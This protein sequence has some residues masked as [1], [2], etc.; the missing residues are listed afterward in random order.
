MMTVYRQQGIA[1]IQVL[2]IAA[3][4]SIFSI[5]IN[6]AAKQQVG[7]AKDYVEKADALLKL[8]T[9]RAQLFNALLTQ[10]KVQNQLSDNPISAVWNFYNKPFEMENGVTVQMQDMAGLLPINQLLRKD[11]Y[12]IAN[13]FGVPTE[14]MDI[15]M[16]SLA[17][18]QDSDDLRRLNGAE[19]QYYIDLGKRPPRNDKIQFVGELQQVRGMTDTLW[20]HLR[21]IITLE[22][23]IE[24]NPYTA[25]LDVIALRYGEGVAQTVKSMRESSHHFDSQQFQLQTGI[26]L[27]EG[28]TFYPGPYQKVKLSYGEGSNMI[29]DYFVVRTLPKNYEAL[30]VR[31]RSEY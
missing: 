16:D 31:L 5:Q 14:Q 29:N 13:Y 22:F 4:L 24:F 8:R 30:Q 10:P 28:E 1:L 2:L 7:L 12:A 27:Q 11:Y 17:D 23:I 25:P 20:N 6:T 19:S 3:I 21:S 15:W 9:A 18:W 26:Y